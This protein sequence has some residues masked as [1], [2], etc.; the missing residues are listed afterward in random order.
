VDLLDVLDAGYAW[1]PQIE[2]HESGPAAFHEP[3]Q[4]RPGMGLADD[5]DIAGAL[6]RPT[7]SEMTIG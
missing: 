5:L 4:F 7:Q 6:D 3:H 2:E 1:H